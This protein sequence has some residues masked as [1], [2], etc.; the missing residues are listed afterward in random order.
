LLYANFLKTGDLLGV[1]D[2]GPEI[3]TDF[4]KLTRKWKRKIRTHRIKKL[5][6]LLKK[7]KDLGKADMTHFWEKS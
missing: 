4:S 3:H 7:F 5:N 2:W 1:H 6:V